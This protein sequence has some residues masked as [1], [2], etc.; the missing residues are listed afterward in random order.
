MVRTICFVSL[1]MYQ[2]DIS[3]T[4]L[5]IVWMIL[6]AVMQLSLLCLVQSDTSFVS[7]EKSLNNFLPN[8]K[9]ILIWQ[10]F[11]LVWEFNVFVKYKLGT[12]N[13]WR[14]LIFVTLVII[15]W[16]W[17]VKSVQYFEYL[18]LSGIFTLNISNL[19]FV[20]G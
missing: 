16:V 17:I 12:Y 7:V 9:R 5:V 4:C 18:F 13:N 3:V 20:S 19:R 1:E 6:I 15:Y 11:N 14:A 10:N 8:K 2:M